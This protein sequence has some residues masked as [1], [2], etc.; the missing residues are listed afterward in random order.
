M[1]RAVYYLTFISILF[2]LGMVA[3]PTETKVLLTGVVLQ[4]DSLKGIPNTNII[5]RNRNVG[6]ASD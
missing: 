3:Q 4:G 6:T 2:S 5:V 1:N